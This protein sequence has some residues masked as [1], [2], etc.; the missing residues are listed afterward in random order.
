[1]SERRNFIKKGALWGGYALG[2]AV[3][4]LPVFSFI[5]YRKISKRKVIFPPDSQLAPVNFKE[6]VYLLSK[7]DEIKA[8]SARC[9]HLGC[10]VNFNGDEKRFKCPCHGSTFN[11][12]GKW[13]S[14]PAK[15]NLEP[16]PIEK[17]PNGD[18]ETVLKI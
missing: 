7:N 3:L 2:L 4:G 5:T 8:L 1:M 13:V 16:L 17:K 18:I 14:G 10:T 15:K 11:A 12:F 6:N 9:P